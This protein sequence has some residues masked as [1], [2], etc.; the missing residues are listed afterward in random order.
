MDKGEVG[1]LGE[2]K[3]E[4]YKIAEPDFPLQGVGSQHPSLPEYYSYF[5]QRTS[6]GE[7]TT[8]GSRPRHH[9]DRSDLKM[10]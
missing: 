3:T 2:E 1:V 10:R 9:L 7:T 4:H 6:V 8:S 5:M